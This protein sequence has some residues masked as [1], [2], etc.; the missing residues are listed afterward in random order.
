MKKTSLPQWKTP[1]YRCQADMKGPCCKQCRATGMVAANW[2]E[3]KT[4]QRDFACPV[5][6]RNGTVKESL[7]TRP[8]AEVSIKNIASLM[9]QWS[10]G[11]MVSEEVAASRKAICAACE[12]RKEADAG[13]YCA[14]PGGCGCTVEPRKVAFLTIGMADITRWVEKPGKRLCAHPKRYMGNG[15]PK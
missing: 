13:A 10:T 12:Y 2:R 11:A 9:S 15:W 1:G 3:E 8:P 6:D 7:T 14:A 4:G 5:L